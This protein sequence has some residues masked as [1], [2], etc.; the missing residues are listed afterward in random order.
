MKRR[1]GKVL[2]AMSGG[3]D[4]SAAA[5]ILKKQGYEVTGMFMRLGVENQDKSEAAARLVCTK[6]N[7]K[8]YPINLSYK[9][10]K[11]VIDYFL[12]SYS[13]GLTPNPCV[14]CNQM[15]K[16]KELLRIAQ[17][18]SMDYLA[19]GHYV[20]NKK[21]PLK[22]DQPL[23]GKIP[24]CAG[25]KNKKTIYKLYRGKDKE[26]EQSYFLYGLTQEQLA[27]ILFPLGD[28]T[29]KQVKDMADK[30]KLPYLVKESQDVCFLS[31]DHNKF[32]K[33]H[34]NLKPGPIKT[35][36]GKKIGQH[37]GLPLYTIGQRKGVEIGG[38]GPFYVAKC[39]YKTNTLYVVEN[40]NDPA[41]YSNKLIAQNVNWIAGEEPKMPLHCEAVIRY[42][43]K[44]TQCQ[45]RKLKSRKLKVERDE[46]SV[47]FSQPQRAITPGQSVVFYWG[48]EVLGGGIIK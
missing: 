14:K 25:R 5:V 22:A 38:I 3:V 35:L 16:F 2:V 11:E 45:V 46:Y 27:H 4:S 37:Q 21:F 24:V 13:S 28:Y 6:L 36:T 7:I 40:G 20:K 29:K 39:D 23:A 1:K 33:E 44:V 9:F 8:F 30:E 42:R 17:E 26:K 41:L 43:H 31:G 32:L 12:N 18:L 48:Q 19:T 47:K 34:L 15:I 10:R